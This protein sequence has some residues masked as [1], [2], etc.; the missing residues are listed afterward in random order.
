MENVYDGDDGEPLHL[1]RKMRFQGLFFDGESQL[2]PVY[3]VGMLRKVYIFWMNNK[4]GK[5]E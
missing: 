3:L 4:H 2:T 5:S 1:V